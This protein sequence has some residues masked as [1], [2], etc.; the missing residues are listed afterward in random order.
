MERSSKL[1]ERQLERDLSTLGEPEWLV[2][3][4]RGQCEI[5]SSIQPQPAAVHRLLA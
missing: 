5:A 4:K 2:L 1:P 3:M